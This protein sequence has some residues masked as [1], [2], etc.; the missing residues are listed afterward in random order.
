MTVNI[1]ELAPDFKLPDQDGKVIALQDL[2]GKNVVLYF[3]PKDNTSGCTVE[4]KDFSCLV[5]D[6]ASCNTVVI[7]MS[8]DGTKSHAKFVIK[9]DLKVTLVSDEEKSVLSA[10]G[11]WVE[12]SMYGKKYM[13]V[14]RSTFLIGIDGVVKAIWRKVSVPSHAETVLKTIKHS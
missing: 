13:G 6:F 14:E 8:P 10:Y 11:V 4:A 12:K 7:G 5:D 1:E 9:H 2:R 3:Y